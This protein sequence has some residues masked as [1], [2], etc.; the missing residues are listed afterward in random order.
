[1][2]ESSF[3]FKGRVNISNMADGSKSSLVNKNLLL[4]EGGNVKTEP[5]MEIFVDDVEAKHGASVAEV[6]EEALYYLQTRGFS[7][8][9]AKR[10]LIDGL[11]SE[12]LVPIKIR[13]LRN[14]IEK[15]FS[16]EVLSDG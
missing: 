4:S 2:D 6:D 10:V 13:S 7:K 16:K 11:F 1:M 12:F 8:E 15:A 9:M 14:F 5:I 3:S